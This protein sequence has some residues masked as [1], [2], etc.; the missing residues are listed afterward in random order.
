MFNLVDVATY[1]RH[2]RILVEV[3]GQTEIKIL[4]ASVAAVS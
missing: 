1:F 2:Q 3:T 4:A